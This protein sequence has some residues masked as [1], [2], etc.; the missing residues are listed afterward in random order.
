MES[1]DMAE[2]D[3]PEEYEIQ[4][5]SD[6]RWIPIT[7]AI[8]RDPRKADEALDK[9]K[10]E[11]KAVR[12]APRKQLY[13]VW[14]FNELAPR[15]EGTDRALREMKKRGEAGA[16]AG[17]AIFK[18]RVE[19]LIGIALGEGKEGSFA[20]EPSYRSTIYSDLE[21]AGETGLIQRIE[22]LWEKYPDRVPRN[23]VLDL[24]EEFNAELDRR[25]G[26]SIPRS[27]S[28]LSREDIEDSREAAKS[29][30]V[31]KA[32]ASAEEEL[33]ELERMKREI[34]EKMRRLRG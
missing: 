6:N 18:Q 33:A 34:E 10:E 11:F 21:A 14:N 1:W 20:R 8:F 17:W 28:E 29:L 24:K 19:Q 23:E 7:G 27:P 2:N 31:K 3:Q 16:I 9:Y 12:V 32:E 25:V 13:E 26:R 5:K 15:L 22:D 4:F 30:Y